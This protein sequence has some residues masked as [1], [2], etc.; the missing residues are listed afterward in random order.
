MLLS[1]LSSVWD[2]YDAVLV[3]TLSCRTTAIKRAMTDCTIGQRESVWPSDSV[4]L[5]SRGRRFDS[6]SV[7]LS[8]QKLSHRHGLIVTFSLPL[9]P[10]PI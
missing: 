3:D 7:L 4:R 2:L 5:V 8:L 1:T 9:S 10:L 6:A